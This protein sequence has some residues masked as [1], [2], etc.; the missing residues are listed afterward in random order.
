MIQKEVKDAPVHPLEYPTRPWQ[1]IHIEFAGPF[2][3]YMWLI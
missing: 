1:Q 3:G 2:Q